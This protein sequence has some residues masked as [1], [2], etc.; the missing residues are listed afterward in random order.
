[1][2]KALE[3]VT[4]L[5]FSHLLQGPFAT[6]L[7]GR[8]GRERHQ[9]RA[10]RR[11]R[12]VP[13]DDLLR[14]MG[15][16][17][18]EP[19]LSRLEPQQAVDRAEPQE[20]KGPRDPHGHGQESRRRG[21]EFPPRRACAPRLRLRGLQGGQPAHHLL[22]RLGLRRGRALRRPPRPG[23]ADPGPRRPRRQHRPRRHGAGAGGRRASPTRSAR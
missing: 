5:D 23:H 6:Q 15:G 22:L 21:A 12:H 8:H 10:R 11:G 19:E 7:L 13:L 1:M 9:D 14:Q 17:L 2:N 16:R 20:P 18:G 4:I 3:G